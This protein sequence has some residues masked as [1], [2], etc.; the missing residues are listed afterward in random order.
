MV[1]CGLFVFSLLLKLVG[2]IYLGIMCAFL[3]IYSVCGVSLCVLGPFELL[4]K[5]W[6]A[7]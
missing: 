7:V 2:C 3:C 5:V 4:V 6:L 1:L